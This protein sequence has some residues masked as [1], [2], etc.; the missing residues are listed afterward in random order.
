MKILVVDD[1][2]TN[3]RVCRAL[4]AG[5]GCSIAEATNGVEALAA[6]R[7]DAPDLILMDVQMPVMD[8]LDALRH[9]LADPATCAIPV[10]ALT[11]YAM[12]GDREHLLQAGFADYLSKPVDIDRFLAVVR[13][14]ATPPGGA[15]PFGGRRVDLTPPNPE[16]LV[17]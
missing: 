9:L 15:D 3:R 17:P 4:L 7:T 6:V 2:A 1:N 8:G 10:V 13:R 16:N 14:F 5:E 12:K 11:A